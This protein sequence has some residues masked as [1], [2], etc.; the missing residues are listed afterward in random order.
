MSAT[1]RRKSSI[2]KIHQSS[3][4]ETFSFFYVLTF[5]FFHFVKVSAAA[6][7][8]KCYQSIKMMLSLVITPKDHH[9]FTTIQD[10]LLVK[11]KP[12]C[13]A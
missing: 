5:F 9:C 1:E 3:G 8:V 7:V 10:W 6:T 12:V 2:T 11:Q 13:T 4:V